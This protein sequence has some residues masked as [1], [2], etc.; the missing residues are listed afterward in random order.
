M[1]ILFFSIA[2]LI[3]GC[4][5]VKELVNSSDTY[6]CILTHTDDDDVD[7]ECYPG[8]SEN[9]CNEYAE[10]SDDYSSQYTS[11]E[12]CEEFCENENP[13]SIMN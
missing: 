2:L 4:S 9:E 8:A 11:D 6:I 1:K 13:C 12:T 3:M 10:A 7:Y 5:K